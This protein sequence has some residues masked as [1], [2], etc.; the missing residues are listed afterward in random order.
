VKKEIFSY[1]YFII[2]LTEK[3]RKLDEKILNS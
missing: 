2:K 3:I 1:H